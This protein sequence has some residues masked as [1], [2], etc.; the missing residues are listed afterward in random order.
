MIPR[1]TFARH[2]PHGAEPEDVVTLSRELIAQNHIEIGRAD[3]KAAV[4]LATGGSLLGLLLIRRPPGT[5]WPHPLWWTATVTTTVALLLLLA[6]LLPR[7]GPRIRESSRILAYY[8]DVVRAE[9]R[10]ELSSGLLLGSS[11]PQPHLFRALTGTSRIA[12]T[13]NRCVHAAILMLL[14]AVTAV[15][16]ALLSRA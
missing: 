13:K 12:R 5:F 1:L 7:H 9:K 8:D 3:G 16:A 14:P 15:C 2:R 6:A 4:L 10:T 11:D